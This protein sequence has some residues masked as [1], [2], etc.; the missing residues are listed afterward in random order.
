MN[1]AIR[2][3]KKWFKE[4][5]LIATLFV[6]EELTR[7][8]DPVKEGHLVAY[9]AGAEGTLIDTFDKDKGKGLLDY[10]SIKKIRSFA[11]LCHKYKKEAWIAGS[12]TKEQLP[13]LWKTGVDVVCVRGA[14]C[15]TGE[16]RMGKVKAGIVKELIKTIP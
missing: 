1:R 15:E 8:V 4:K 10:I 2:N 13:G 14:A 9:E 6:D 3:V 7:F 16:G 5:T 11:K 12:I